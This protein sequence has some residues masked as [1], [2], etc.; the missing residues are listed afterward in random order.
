[1]YIYTY[2]FVSIF[3]YVCIYEPTVGRCPM[4]VVLLRCSVKELLTR[5]EHASMDKDQVGTE[6]GMGEGQ[7]LASLHVGS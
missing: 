5:V 2:I 7:I 6:A 3:V 4:R 1:M